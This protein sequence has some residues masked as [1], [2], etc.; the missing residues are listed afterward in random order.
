MHKFQ[1]ALHCEQHRSRRP[2]RLRDARDTGDIGDTRDTGDI[3][4]TGDTRDTGEACTQS[5]A[6]WLVAGSGL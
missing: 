4:D 2:E 3:R 6:G 5:S 1:P